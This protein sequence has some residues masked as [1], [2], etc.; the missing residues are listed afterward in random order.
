MDVN[1]PKRG[2][3]KVL[4]V[5][6]VFLFLFLCMYAPFAFFSVKDKFLYLKHKTEFVKQKVKVDSVEVIVA[7]T[8][9]VGVNSFYGYHVHYNNSQDRVTVI[10]PENNIIVSKQ[11][12]AEFNHFNEI[13]NATPFYLPKNDSIYIWHHSKLQDRYATKQQLHL[14]TPNFIWHII[15]N[16]IILI[17]VIW[18]LTWQIT[19]WLKLKRKK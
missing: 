14:N 5:V 17:L 18:G 19:Q 15:V 9:N 13:D 16:S 12:A 3:N 10:S 1:K 4:N 2:I 6:L 8:H 11:E 7:G